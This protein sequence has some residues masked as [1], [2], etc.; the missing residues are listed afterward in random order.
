MFSFHVTTRFP[1]LNGLAV[2]VRDETPS[3]L[4]YGY[5]S[6]AQ[7]ISDDEAERR[8]L[9]RKCDSSADHEREADALYNA[10]MR[11]GA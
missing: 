11:A 9:Y 7:D 1:N 10:E 6:L 2:A 3:V 8:G 4:Y 5:V